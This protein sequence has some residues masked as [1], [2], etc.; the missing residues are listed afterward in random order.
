MFVMLVM[1]YEFVLFVVWILYGIMFELIV[2]VLCCFVLVLF[3]VCMI[4]F[5]GV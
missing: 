5:F 3:M 2:V 1:I 4:D